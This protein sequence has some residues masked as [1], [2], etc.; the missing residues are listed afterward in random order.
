MP[1]G[2]GGWNSDEAWGVLRWKLHR[3]NG[4]YEGLHLADP[5]D[6]LPMMRRCF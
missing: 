6:L 3:Q 2:V 5:G 4:G 1:M